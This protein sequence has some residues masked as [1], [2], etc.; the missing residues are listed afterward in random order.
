VRSRCA[1]SLTAAKPKQGGFG[2]TKVFPTLALP[3][4]RDRETV[5][6]SLPELSGEPLGASIKKQK[7]YIITP[8]ENKDIFNY[9]I[10]NIPFSFIILPNEWGN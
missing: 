1:H 7:P 10:S 4:T 9:W 8:Y 3:L 2:D 5:S 6:N